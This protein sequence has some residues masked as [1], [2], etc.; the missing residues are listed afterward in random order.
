MLNTRKL[1][2]IIDLDYLLY[3]QTLSDK[4]SR[5]GNK[6]N[7]NENHGSSVMNS[8][9]RAIAIFFA[10]VMMLSLLPVLT[11]GYS[12]HYDL[13]A[14]PDNVS[15]I[16]PNRTVTA[17]NYEIQESSSY[18][19]LNY[20]ISDYS[21]VNYT[22]QISKYLAW[23]SQ[24]VFYE[25]NFYIV[26]GSN[27]V[28]MSGA[29]GSQPMVSA[30][31]INGGYC[32]FVS[33]SKGS[34]ILGGNYFTPMG[35][36][37]MF[38]Y[39]I[40]T[41]VLSN[42]SGSLPPSVAR[43][44]SGYTIVG[45][46]EYDNLT[47]VIYNMENNQSQLYSEKFNS[48]E[49]VNI[50]NDFKLAGW[51]VLT[52]SGGGYIL[53]IG[54]S[55]P[56][57]SY[58]YNVSTGRFTA[59]SNPD[60]TNIRGISCV[61]EVAY[62]NG[63]FIVG[64]SADLYGYNPATNSTSLLNQY[65]NYTITFLTQGPDGSVMFG[66]YLGGYTT[67]ILMKNGV[68][69]DMGSYYGLINDASFSTESNGI[70]LIGE[71]PTSETPVSY[72]IVPSSSS[73]CFEES[74]LPSGTDWTLNITGSG[75][76]ESYTTGASEVQLSLEYGSYEIRTESSLKTYYA[77]SQ[78]INV[79]SQSS[80]V[81]IQFLPYYYN[82]SI[83]ERGLPPNTGWYAQFL[84][85]NNV[86]VY[87]FSTANG[88]TG[89]VQLQNGTYSYS[90]NSKEPQWM[91]LN[92]CGTL[93]VN[94]ANAS[95]NVTFVEAFHVRF[96]IY[97]PYI[98]HTWFLN[99]T[100][101]SEYHFK[102]TGDV[103]TSYGYLPNGTYIYRGATTMKKY[104]NPGGSF[105]VNGR[106]TTVNITFTP[107]LYNITFLKTGSFNVGRWGVYINGSSLVQNNGTGKFLNVSLT[108]GTYSLQF[109]DD[110]VNYQPNIIDSELIVNG[111]SETV[112]IT[113]VRAYAVNFSIPEILP[114]LW[115]VGLVNSTGFH[116][117]MSSSGRDLS[118]HLKNDTYSY[119]AVYSG[120]HLILSPDT[121]TITV[122]G[123]NV[124]INL[125]LDT[126]YSVEFIESGLFNGTS[127]YVNATTVTGNYRAAS[128][129]SDLKICMPTGNFNFSGE[130]SDKVFSYETGN[131][132]VT[133]SNTSVTVKFI[134]VTYPTY[135]SLKNF[136]GSEFVLAMVPTGMLKQLIEY[137]YYSGVKRV[138]NFEYEVNLTNGTYT[139]N[140]FLINRT[141]S[142]DGIFI[143]V[144]GASQ[145]FSLNLRPYLYQVLFVPSF[146]AGMSGDWSVNGFNGTVNSD[147]AIYEIN[148]THSY[149]IQ[150]PSS[151]FINKSSGS[152]TVNGSDVV[153]RVGFSGKNSIQNI[154][155][156]A[157]DYLYSEI[158]VIS[159]SYI[160]VL[161]AA[162]LILSA[163]SSID[164]YRSIKKMRQRREK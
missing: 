33:P 76:N 151:V 134:P 2:K 118:F 96:G 95:I 121:G 100:L 138:G 149:N 163:Y 81:K 5:L 21:V 61:N 57:Y 20:N 43:S 162:V 52:S 113:F 102:F 34:L 131:G 120:Y 112:N 111:S 70:L 32:R 94:G 28:K 119:S 114:D 55:Y 67:L 144:Q 139:A 58:I 7:I 107:Y 19:G 108:N 110:D 29:S 47:Y 145:V 4:L 18:S 164:A 79:S 22:S 30:A 106:N 142:L 104:S 161:A 124:T 133:G 74:G 63:Q 14:N 155:G 158:N 143:S 12:A 40:S 152:F 35:G 15:T 156:Q 90:I 91:L 71:S 97:F 46:Q 132:V 80:T 117:N 153:I 101:D 126:A 159:N 146:P 141:Y 78:E 69:H 1:K 77:S 62:V 122:R 140:A 125:A 26:G 89:H 27:L 129:T 150:A 49:I 41:G 154:E 127:W 88:S 99:A 83:N 73:I 85:Q 115:Y 128:D 31:T 3:I 60:L 147:I 23:T 160:P 51:D 148:G 98:T 37:Y 92:N 11:T 103:N 93:I 36:L 53:F 39:G 75:F 87:V 25:G 42:L 44:G 84:W 24:D 72:Y 105:T 45:M 56:G 157:L 116:T 6:N 54:N 68:F 109:C 13:T 135:F 59:L 82:V 65:P 130:S 48:T 86:D 66:I 9:G 64:N 16:H 137:D 8:S 123:G 50:T 136:N 17:K 38:S 10:A